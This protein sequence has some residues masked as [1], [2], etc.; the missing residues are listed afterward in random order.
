MS[1]CASQMWRGESNCD[2]GTRGPFGRPGP[3]RFLRVQDRPWRKDGERGRERVKPEPRRPHV[4]LAA[5]PHGPRLGRVCAAGYLGTT[6]GYLDREA[7]PTWP[8][9][10]HPRCI[11]E[12]V[13]RCLSRSPPGPRT[14]VV[15]GSR[16]PSTSFSSIPLR[17]RR[18]SRPFSSTHF[19]G[20]L[21]FS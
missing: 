7:R 14:A 4:R 16:L 8:W 21:D 19:F 3:V 12:V 15:G 6:T 18:H 1:G 13:R 17:N 20:S 9:C 5:I 2:A 11:S 10:C